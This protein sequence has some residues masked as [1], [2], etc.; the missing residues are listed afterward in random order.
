MLAG[1]RGFRREHL[2]HYRPRVR[3]SEGWLASRRAS[4]VAL[5]SNPPAGDAPEVTRQHSRLIAFELSK[6]NRGRAVPCTASVRSS[7][8]SVRAILVARDGVAGHCPFPDR[9]REIQ[10]VDTL[11]ANVE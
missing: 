7:K 1:Q 5:Q 3:A 9:T 8:M 11:S 6:R 2:S 4:E 10:F